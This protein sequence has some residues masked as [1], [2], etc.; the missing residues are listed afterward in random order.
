MRTHCWKWTW[1]VR[2]VPRA[3]EHAML[4]YVYVHNEKQYVACEWSKLEIFIRTSF[5]EDHN[6]N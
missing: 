1:A 4:C 2:V 5:K 3:R 6:N